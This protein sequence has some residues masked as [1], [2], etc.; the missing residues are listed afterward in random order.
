MTDQISKATYKALVKVLDEIKEDEK[1]WREAKN[2]GLGAL[3]RRGVTL[4]KKLS[5]QFLDVKASPGKVT[6]IGGRGEPRITLPAPQRPRCRRIIKVCETRVV[7]V[8]HAG[9]GPSRYRVEQHCVEVCD[10][11]TAVPWP[12]LYTPA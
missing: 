1:L 9:E 12:R 11:K 2:D 8:A 10:P 7:E 3:K 4:P 5:V 6:Y